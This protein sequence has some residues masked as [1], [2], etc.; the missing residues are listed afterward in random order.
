[1][2]LNP[3]QIKDI[4]FGAIEYKE[5]EDGYLHPLRFTKAQI[6]TLGRLRKDWGEKAYATSGV[7]FDFYTDSTTL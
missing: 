3:P 6:E 1:M 4:L 5:T 7:C 2:T